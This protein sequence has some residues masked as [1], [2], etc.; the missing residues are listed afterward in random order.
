MDLQVWSLVSSSTKNSDL[1]TPFFLFLFD[2]SERHTQGVFVS[3]P[4]FF[5]LKSWVMLAQR[6]TVSTR[7]IVNIS[8]QDEF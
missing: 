2:V 3:T 4:F 1:T 8:K 7:F 6:S 5:L